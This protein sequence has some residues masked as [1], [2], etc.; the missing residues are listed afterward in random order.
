MQK[1]ARKNALRQTRAQ[2]HAWDGRE[3]RRS[4]RNKPGPSTRTPR[5]IKQTPVLIGRERH[6][7]FLLEAVYHMANEVTIADSQGEIHQGRVLRVK[8]K[9]HYRTGPVRPERIWEQMDNYRVFTR[10]ER[11]VLDKMANYLQ[12]NTNILVDRSGQYLTPPMMADLF[13][14]DRSNLHKALRGLKK[15]NA[16]GHW[17]AANDH[18]M[19]NP[20]LFFKGHIDAVTAGMF[21]R[22]A[23]KRVKEGMSTVYINRNALS[24]VRDSVSAT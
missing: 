15:K 23:R 20:D 11:D 1:S 19:I 6:R 5:N 16:I 22:E 9:P 8:G 4:L 17:D 3:D 18:W 10:L 14:M 7:G 21:R 13:G 12:W 2:D 24:V